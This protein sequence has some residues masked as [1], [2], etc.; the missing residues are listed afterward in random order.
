[1]ERFISTCV[2]GNR[3]RHSGFSFLQPC[4]STSFPTGAVKVDVLETYLYKYMYIDGND[5]KLLLNG[6]Q[7]G[8]SLQYTGPRVAVKG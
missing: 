2:C 6:F 4:R 1:M 5:A 3:S 8:F 7:H